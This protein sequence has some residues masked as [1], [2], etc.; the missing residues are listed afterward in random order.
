MCLIGISVIS[1]NT[2]WYR[3]EQEYISQFIQSFFFWSEALE[4]L[5]GAYFAQMLKIKEKKDGLIFNIGGVAAYFYVIKASQARNAIF[6][7][8]A[9][10]KSN[11]VV[12]ATETLRK[13]K[14]SF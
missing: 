7:Y 5:A 3:S 11:V 9:S 8:Q 1:G 10:L 13:L 6:A 12:N 2:L 14:R 4:H